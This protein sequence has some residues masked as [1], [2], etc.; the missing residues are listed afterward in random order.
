M[1]TAET[2]KVPSSPVDAGSKFEQFTNDVYGW[3]YRLVGRHH[4]ALD[5]VQDVFL[6]WTSQCAKDAPQQPR[7]WLRRVTLNRSIDL[8]RERRTGDASDAALLKTAGAAPR[9]VGI[10][11]NE[12]RSDVSAA[13]E[14]LT[15]VQRSVL[16]AKVYDGL[17]FAQIAEEL[18]LAV[19][20]AKT[21]YVRA[22]KHVG[23][24]L[25]PRWDRE[26]LS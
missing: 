19:S 23:T 10:E 15:D 20:T 26:D 13:L 11:Q 24:R 3:A 12:L 25:Q 5:V 22:I 21:H 8:I 16:V 9:L 7:S 17:T 14:A 4:D 2:T 6:R 18:S 1:M